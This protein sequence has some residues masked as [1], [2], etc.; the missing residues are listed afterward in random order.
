LQYETLVENPEQVVRE[1]LAYCELPW[2]AQ[3]LEFHRRKTSVATPSAAQVR[4][5][6]YT[7]SVDR[8]RRYGDVMQPL[9]ALLQ[10]AGFYA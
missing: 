4:Q 8:W 7:S 10:S 5:G 2:E 3:C 9:Y 1:L 6:I